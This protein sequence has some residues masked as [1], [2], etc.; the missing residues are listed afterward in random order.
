MKQHSMTRRVVTLVL[1]V[2]LM[3]ALL[4]TG[5]VSVYERHSHLR[6]FDVALRG[7][8]DTVMGAVS[9]GPDDRTEGLALDT[10][11]LSLPDTDVYAVREEGGAIL[12]KS[13][14]WSSDRRFADADI[15]HGPDGML[16]L[17]SGGEEYRAVRLHRVRV[18][19]PGA[20]NV[21][22]MVVVI[23]GS[24]V[25]RVWH[26]VWESVRVLA[27]ANVALVLA[28]A[29]LVPTIV[30]RSTR[31]LTLLAQQAALI[32]TAHWRFVP[33]EEVRNVE[34]LRP[35]AEALEALIHRLERSF[36][37]QQQFLSDGAHELKTSIAVVKSSVQLLGMRLRTPEEYAEGL[38][39]CYVDCLRMEELAQKMLLL[40]RVEDVAEGSNEHGAT[41]L[42]AGIH[43]AIEEL[44]P[45]AEMR[46]VGFVFP[47]EAGCQE[48][49]E[50]AISG[51][52]WRSLIVN[53]LMNAVQHSPRHGAVTVSITK[54]AD[55]AEFVVQ[56]QGS[57][58]AAEALPYI[59][60]RFYRGDASRSRET[61]GTGL[62]LAICKAI[63]E[64]VKGRIEIG[65]GEEGGTRVMVEVPLTGRSVDI[66]EVGSPERTTIL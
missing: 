62:G 35:L 37:Q 48:A 19:D 39:R 21:R 30:R 54:R 2:E 25:R 60:D 15:W 6:S 65:R 9:E 20:E 61:G 14:S 64:R 50:G 58:V 33:G 26:E 46:G 43:S 45:V 41:L 38:E 27:L 59:F 4:V 49:L 13:A 23:Y 66:G 31:P 12:G 47:R 5:F 17:R 55:R 11:D 7:R 44:G 51:D 34:E 42:A 29:L 40:A 63:V 1:V 3:A 22:H 24:P 10:A 32:S 18:V 28:S 36:A 56:D 53:L 57:G 16:M 8:A 52:M